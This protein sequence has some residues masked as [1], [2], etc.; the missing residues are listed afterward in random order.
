[1]S[2]VKP[3]RM[4]VRE[5][6]Q[7]VDRLTAERDR[8][9]KRTAKYRKTIRDMEETR[10]LDLEELW[11]E[12]TNQPYDDHEIDDILIE[13]GELRWKVESVQATFQHLSEDARNEWIRVVAARNVGKVPGNGTP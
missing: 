11:H 1:V 6:R 7:K 9:V 13:V 2:D 8:A 3:K 10:R 4:T 5:L 12:A